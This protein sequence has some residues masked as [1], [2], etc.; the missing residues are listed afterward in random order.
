MF[1]LLLGVL[2]PFFGTCLGAFLVF[3]LKDNFNP[4]LNKIMLGFAG[5]VMIASSIWSLIIPAINQSKYMAFWRFIPAFCGICLGVLF[6]LLLDKFCLNLSDKSQKINS[7]LYRKNILL[8]W[9]VTVHN[10]PEGLAVGVVLASAYFGNFEISIVSALALSVGIAVQNIPE[11]LIVSMPLISDNISKKR[12]FGFGVLSGIVEPIF[13]CLAIFLTK[14]IEPI[15]PYLLSFA[16]GAMIYVS[17]EELIPESHFEDNSK[18]STISFV[19][20]FLIMM[21]LDI[22]LS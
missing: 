9:V 17:I 3:F 15:L 12:A 2:V 22:L 6:M 19:V 5:G 10:I 16:A 1:E 14:I 20:G 11:G 21:I 13:A 8:F 4:K 7:N 18:L